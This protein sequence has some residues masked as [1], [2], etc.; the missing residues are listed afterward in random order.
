MAQRA[1]II[2]FGK[3]GRTRAAALEKDGRA[4]ISKVYDSDLP[5]DVSYPVAESIDAIVREPEIDLVFICLPNYLNFPTTV[6]ALR[7]GKH[8]FCEKPPAFNAD[9]MR[10]VIQVERVCGKVLMYG[11]NHRHHARRI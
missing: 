4:V 5:S 6:A 9:E 7:A 1:G 11:F 8:V 3:M 10:Q 2:G